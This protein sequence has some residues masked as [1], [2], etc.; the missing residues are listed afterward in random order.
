MIYVFF[1][2][3]LFSYAHAIQTSATAALT[4][5]SN[6]SEQKCGICL[7]DID[8]EE[9]PLNAFE[10]TH[11]E[12]SFHNKCI[13]ALFE[14]SPSAPCP[15][16]RAKKKPK[17]EIKEKPF[18]EIDLLA[19]AFMND[20]DRRKNNSTS[21]HAKPKKERKEKKGAPKTPKTHDRR[22]RYNSFEVN[23]DEL[24]AFRLDPSIKG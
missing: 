8:S 13:S 22:D 23:E 5:A 9:E 3:A 10:C 11:D 20:Y 21:P 16:C 1:L 2:I 24:A 18:D 15:I 12:H 14:H 19:L 4:H 17:A 6:E 7:S